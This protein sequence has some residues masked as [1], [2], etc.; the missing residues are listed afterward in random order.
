[1]TNGNESLHESTQYTMA[2]EA[3]AAVVLAVSIGLSGPLKSD[4]MVELCG[5][6]PLQETMSFYIWILLPVMVGRW[7]VYGLYKAPEAYQKFVSFSFALSVYWN[8]LFGFWTLQN[9]SL[10]IEASNAC[11][12]TPFSLIKLTYHVLLIFG[13]FPAIILTVGFVF[14]MCFLPYFVYEKFQRERRRRQ[15]RVRTQKL[16]KSLFRS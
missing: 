10:M 1:M 4:P 7:F 13:A 11:D 9:F 15:E 12:R 5:L 8:V 14:F 6:D 3:I 16:L 2:Y